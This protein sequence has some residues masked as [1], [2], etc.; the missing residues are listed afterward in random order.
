MLRVRVKT[1]VVWEILLRKNMSQN[2][3]GKAAG[4]SSGHISQL[5]NGARCPT[6]TVRRKLLDALAPADFDTIFAIEEGPDGS[7]A[8]PA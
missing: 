5:I 1:Q 4:I 7:A 2:D 6:P 8:N 3:L